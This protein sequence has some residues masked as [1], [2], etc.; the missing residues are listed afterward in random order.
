MPIRAKK[1]H[2]T[3]DDDIRLSFSPVAIPQCSFE[4]ACRITAEAGFRGIALRYNLFV[5]FLARG[6]TVADARNLM[7]RYGLTFN[8]GGFLAE[9][10]FH[11]GLPLVCGR[12]RNGG[13]GEANDVLLR[14]L[15]TFFEHCIELECSNI[16]AATALWDSGDLSVA[17]ADFAQLCDYADPYGARIGLEFMGHAPQVRDIKT[18]HEIVSIA[19]RPNGGIVVDTFFIHQGGSTLA[20]IAAVPIDRIFNVQLADAKPLPVDQLNMLEDRLFPGEGAANVRDVVVLLRNRGY[21]G[22]WTVELF[23]PDYRRMPAE[24]VAK[25]AYRTAS[26]LFSQGQHAQERCPS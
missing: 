5:D 9:W 21:S 23:N 1:S 12:K 25:Q 17:G 16:T 2:S 19:N 4:D 26:A 11:G 22:W 3:C 24:N 10:Q 20:D 14:Q 13:A 15:Q 8:E 7:R 18:A 6:N